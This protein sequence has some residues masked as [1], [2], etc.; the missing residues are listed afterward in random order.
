MQLVNKLSYNSQ[1][2]PAMLTDGFLWFK[3]LTVPDPYGIL[4]FVAGGINL[5]NLLNSPMSAGSGMF[6]KVRK[7]LYILPLI[8]IPV[9]MTF[10]VAFNLYWIANSS[11]QLLI[12][13]LFRRDKFRRWMGVP[14]FLPGSKLEREALRRGQISL[15]GS[16]PD[17]KNAVKILN[18]KPKG[19]SAGLKNKASQVIRNKY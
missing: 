11:V 4:P 19:K 7:Y 12:L 13:L 16:L 18:N 9:W 14:D 17:A 15:K 8:S 2:N 10:P 5:L 6:K 1:I 3:D